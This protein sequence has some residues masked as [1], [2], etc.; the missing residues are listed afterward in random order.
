MREWLSESSRDLK[1]ETL[2][3]SWGKASESWWSLMEFLVQR[4]CILTLNSHFLNVLFTDFC[5]LKL[6]IRKYNL[7]FISEET[8]TWC[9]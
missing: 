2:M 9:N 7:H 6:K 4:T 5:F 3:G 8:E 1:R